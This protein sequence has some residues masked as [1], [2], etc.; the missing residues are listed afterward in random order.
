M[1]LRYKGRVTKD[2][3]K[4]FKEDMIT[5]KWDNPNLE[6]IIVER[7]CPKCENKLFFADKWYD[8]EKVVVFK[9]LC[10]R[11]RRVYVLVGYFDEYRNAKEYFI[12]IFR[13]NAYNKKYKNKKD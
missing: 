5:L 1:T 11:C 3:V 7:I 10:V 2:A 6:T 12:N 13:M 9:R 4:C 8:K